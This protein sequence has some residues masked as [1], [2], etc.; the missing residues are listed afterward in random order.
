MKTGYKATYNFMCRGYVFE[1]GHSYEL[2]ET[3]RPCKYGFHYCVNPKDVLY[4]YPIRNCF[5]LLEIEDLGDS[6]TEGN[7]TAT[8]K[9]RII[10]EIPKE[11]YY[12]LFG[13]VNNEFTFEDSDGFWFKQKF[14]ENNNEIYIEDSDGFWFKREYDENNI[15]LKIE[16]GLK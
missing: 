12:P 5:R 9:I 4:Y 8:N 13:I 7:K 16:S 2:K 1:I 15:C 6:V 10:R 3:P 11:E 14:D